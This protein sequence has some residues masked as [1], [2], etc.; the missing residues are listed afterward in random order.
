LIDLEKLLRFQGIKRIAKKGG[1][2]K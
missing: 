2:L 1:A